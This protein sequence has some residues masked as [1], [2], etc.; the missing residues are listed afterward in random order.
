MWNN[1][2][3]RAYGNYEGKFTEAEAGGVRKVVKV[4]RPKFFGMLFDLSD[5]LW[6]E[7]IVGPVI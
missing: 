5:P 6:E 3:L 7:I 2:D 4:Y 1:K